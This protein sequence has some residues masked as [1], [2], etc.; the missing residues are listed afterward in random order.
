MVVYMLI[1][2]YA[3][4]R[5]IEKTTQIGLRDEPKLRKTNWYLGMVVITTYAMMTL[6]IVIEVLLNTLIAHPMF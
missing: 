2:T 6:T 1:K 5:L 4:I 3:T